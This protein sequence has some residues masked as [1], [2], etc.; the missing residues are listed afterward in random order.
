MYALISYVYKIR[1]QTTNY[2]SSFTYVDRENGRKRN[3]H[4]IVF[5]I[6][7]FNLQNIGN[8]LTNLSISYSLHVGVDLNQ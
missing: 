4:N 3:T 1:T 2:V 8:F 6:L 5:R 7:P